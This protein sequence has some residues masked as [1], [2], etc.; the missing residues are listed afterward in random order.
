ML[1]L[2]T[3]CYS[4]TLLECAQAISCKQDVT[5]WLRCLKV[6]VGRLDLSVTSEGGG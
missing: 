3:V 1:T 4:V 5:V 2:K 6:T